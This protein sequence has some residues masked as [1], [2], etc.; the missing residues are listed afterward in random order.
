MR[1]YFLFLFLLV[2]G[3]VEAQKLRKEDKQLIANLQEHIKYLASDELQ[4]RR[5]GTEGEALAMKYI[6]NEFKEAGL[7]PKGTNGYLQPFTVNEG[8]QVNPSTHLMVGGHALTLYKE[9]FPLA[10]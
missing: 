9:F 1:N 7:L 5:T 6:S 3:A 8:K 4:G 2:F 10:F